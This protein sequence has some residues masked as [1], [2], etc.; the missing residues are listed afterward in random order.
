[1]DISTWQKVRVYL[2]W[3]WWQDESLFDFLIGRYLRDY[4]I[5][6]CDEELQLY[7]CVSV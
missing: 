6:I 4:E 1:M 5:D 7:L 2:K 3:L